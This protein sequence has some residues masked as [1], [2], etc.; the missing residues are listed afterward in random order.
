MKLVEALL[1]IATSAVE[2]RLWVGSAFGTLGRSAKRELR[3]VA[4]GLTELLA[5]LL[6]GRN[7]VVVELVAGRGASILNVATEGS[8]LTM[9]QTASLRSSVALTAF[10]RTT[11]KPFEPLSNGV[12]MTGTT[13][14]CSI[15]PGV[16]VSVSAT[17]T[18]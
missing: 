6:L 14:V 16:N 18:K 5:V 9:V 11:K 15:V 10:V 17:G 13:R 2:A 4:G 12:P 7:G 8:L 1:S 3:N